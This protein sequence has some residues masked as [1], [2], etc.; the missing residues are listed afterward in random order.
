ML[1]PMSPWDALR[2]SNDAD[3]YFNLDDG[4]EV[5]L[6]GGN[7]SVNSVLLKVVDG[8]GRFETVDYPHDARLY[9]KVYA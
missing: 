9:V 2:R 1:T 3:I 5:F 4:R 8:H 7:R 6:S